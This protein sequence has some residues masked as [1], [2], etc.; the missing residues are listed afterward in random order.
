MPAPVYPIAAAACRDAS[1]SRSRMA[2]M[3]CTKGEGA[4]S[5]IFWW[6]RWIEHSRSP[7]AHTVPY[8]SAITCTSI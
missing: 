1:N 5:M 6:R 3:R 4:S 7:T 2:G 8:R